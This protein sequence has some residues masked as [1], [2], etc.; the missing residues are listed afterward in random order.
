MPRDDRKI[1]STLQCAPPTRYSSNISRSRSVTI[2]HV[3]HCRF[4]TS[5]ELH[6]DWTKNWPHNRYVDARVMK[7]QEQPCDDASLDAAFQGR[8]LSAD[9]TSAEM[10]CKGM[11]W[12]DSAKSPD[13]SGKY[14]SRFMARFICMLVTKEASIHCPPCGAI[15]QG[16]SRRCLLVK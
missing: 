6:R 13:E 4:R 2:N 11:Y 15:M 5:Q 14:W 16:R 8:S 12:Y 10:S 7:Q 3:S 1:L 9:W